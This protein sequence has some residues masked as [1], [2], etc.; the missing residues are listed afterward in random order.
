MKGYIHYI[1]LFVL[2][3]NSCREKNIPLTEVNREEKLSVLEQII[4]SYQGND[5]KFSYYLVEEDF[6]E[7][8]RN[9]PMFSSCDI[10]EIIDFY[11]E[12]KGETP[13]VKLLTFYESETSF[14]ILIGDF[15]SFQQLEQEYTGKR[16]HHSSPYNINR[17]VYAGIYMDKHG[18]S[19]TNELSGYAYPIFF[20]LSHSNFL[21][22]DE[23]LDS[24]NLELLKGN[25]N[26]IIDSLYFVN[27]E[28][29][30]RILRAKIHSPQNVSF[31]DLIENE[32]LDCSIQ[33]MRSSHWIK[34]EGIQLEKNKITYA[35]KVDAKQLGFDLDSLSMKQIL[36]IKRDVFLKRDEKLTEF[37]LF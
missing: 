10:D 33:K 8:P 11:K 14:T 32:F 25:N 28:S 26:Y 31:F 6:V 13:H 36:M 23:N 2:I 19:S 4:N 35:T 16:E 12:E 5:S 37:E 22:N 27:Q 15:A 1:I 20:F 9:H 24:F 21:P 7:W 30:K 34:R 18:I 3:C 29:K 17:P